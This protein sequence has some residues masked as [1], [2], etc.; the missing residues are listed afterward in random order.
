MALAFQCARFLRDYRCRPAGQGL[1]K[2]GGFNHPLVLSLSKDGRGW[3][4]KLTMSGGQRTLKSPGAA[5]RYLD[6]L[7]HR[8]LES[9]P[10]KADEA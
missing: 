1:F 6:R 3:F 7:S 9:A 10:E 5:G 4:D 2:V 8:G